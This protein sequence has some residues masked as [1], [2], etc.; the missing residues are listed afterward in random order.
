[1]FK[2][3]AWTAEQ[4]GAPKEVLT[5]Q[6]RDWGDPPKGFMLVKVD[7]AG[8][9]LPDL[10]MTRGIYPLVP[11]PP[12]TPGQE[13]A[14]HVVATRAGSPFAIG[15]RIVGVTAYSEGSGGLA[16]YAFVNEIHSTRIPSTLSDDEAAGFYIG[17]R[18]A[19]AALVEGARLR[20]GE[21]LLGLGGACGFGATA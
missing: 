15:D 9:A 5:L 3:R 11:N 4:F 16:E 10:M 6:D 2:G 1:M 14:G 18:T 20:Q 7:A 12:V 21:F 19:Y 17:F 8:V 13:V